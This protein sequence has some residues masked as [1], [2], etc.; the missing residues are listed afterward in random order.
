M[1]GAGAGKLA[2]PRLLIVLPKWRVT[3]D[4]DKPSW[5]SK[6]DLLPASAARQTIALVM[7]GRSE[8]F[9]EE[10][11]SEWPINDIGFTPKGAGAVQLLSS[12]KI[13][14]VVGGGNGAL[15]GEI[16]EGDR[17]ILILSDPD[18]MSNHG[19]GRGENAV[20]MLAL[21]D[22]LRFWNND[23]PDAPVVFDETVHGWLETR[24]SPAGLLF[25]FPFAVVTVLACC[26]AALA[27]LAG[28][29]RFGAPRA[30]MPGLCFGRSHLIDNSARLLDYGGHHAVVLARYARMTIRLAA[31]SLHAPA[32]L[33]EQAAAEWLDRVGRAR[34][35]SRSC[36]AILRNTTDLGTG[37][38]HL[39]KL[40][41]NAREIYLWKGE[42][43]IGSSAHR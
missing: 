11:P 34:G 14:T 36:S 30:G 42:I 35:V 29:G 19:I 9:R 20:F 22:A 2:A 21:I 3:R 10:W 33:D 24:G 12:D 41:E 28:M 16:I 43:L 23:D 7:G 40:I 31:Q 18:V 15:V 38:R 5:V 13:R 6:A 32:G 27:A 26:S 8:V 17:R 1:S 37:E 4:K 25:S 39:L